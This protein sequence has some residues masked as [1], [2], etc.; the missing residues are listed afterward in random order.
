[1]TSPLLTVKEVSQLLRLRPCS[2]R[3]LAHRGEVGFFRVGHAM[4][5]SQTDVEDYLNRC[6]RP[7]RGETAIKRAT[8]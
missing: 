8:R 5:F 3:A 6:R 4:L 2:V 1:V 7:T